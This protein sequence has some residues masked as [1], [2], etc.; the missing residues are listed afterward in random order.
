MLFDISHSHK[1]LK[2]PNWRC[3]ANLRYLC[4]IH[5][6][7]TKCIYAYN[8]MDLRQWNVHRMIWG[9]IF[10]L[11][12]ICFYVILCAKLSAA[13]HEERWLTST[14][15]IL[16]DEVLL[17]L[18]LSRFEMTFKWIITKRFCFVFCFQCVFDLSPISA[19]HATH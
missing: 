18:S 14:D 12:L 6:H 15:K 5:S 2:L 4:V 16:T 8:E 13:K 7:I 10:V 17:C 3:E 9:F 19:Y 1:M 11:L